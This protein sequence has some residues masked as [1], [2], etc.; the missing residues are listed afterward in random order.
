MSV[1]IGFLPWILFWFL[2]GA[3]EFEAAAAAGL[4][5]SAAWIVWTRAEHKQAKIL[6]IGGLVFFA[7]MVVVGFTAD[8]DWFARWS[9][10]ISNAALGAI[11][12]LSIVLGQPFTRQYAKEGAPP[13]VWETASFKRITS[14]LTWMWVAIM[15]ANT[16]LAWLAVEFPD[17]E[18]W[19]GLIV[20]IALV[21]VGLRLNHW[22][23]EHERARADAA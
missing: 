4:V 21:I 6:D 8:E 3:N 13:E 16:V 9:Y 23:P 17:D 11:M 20:P 15:A 19:L 1:L 22:Y 7:I 12:L 2:A 10:M 18:L 14:T 5:A